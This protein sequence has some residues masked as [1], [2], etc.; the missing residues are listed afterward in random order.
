MNFLNPKDSTEPTDSSADNPPL[1]G[2]L[3]D[4]SNMFN[5]RG[6]YKSNGFSFDESEIINDFNG[7]LIYNIPLYNYKLPGDLIFDVG[8][9]YNGS[10]SHIINTGDTSNINNYTSG[11]YNMNFPEW[12]INING[13]GVQTLNFETNFFSNVIETGIVSGNDVHA[14]IPG[15]HFGNQLRDPSSINPDKINILAGD[16]SIISLVNDRKDTSITGN[17]SYEGKELFY[18]AR[19]SV[20]ENDGYWRA[21]NRKVELMRGDGLIFIF[22][23][24]KIRFSDFDTVSSI[25][26][27]LRPK[28]LLLKSIKDRYNNSINLSYSLEHPY[29]M[30]NIFGRPLITGIGF[31][32]GFSTSPVNSLYFIFGP[33]VLKIDHRS[34]INGSYS[35]KLT[36]PVAF[37]PVDQ[38]DIKNHRG[39]I[40][41]IRNILGQVNTINYENY[42]RTFSPVINPKLSPATFMLALNNL[43][44][45]TNFRNT[46]GG[47]R[48]YSYFQD[49]SIGVSLV[50]YN[51]SQEII[52]SE[53][54][55]K[56]YGRDPFYVNMLSSK[57][58]S[59]EY[60]LPISTTTFSYE[61]Y[62]NS[63][64]SLNVP[65]DTSDFYSSTRE[66]TNNLTGT[67]WDVTTSQQKKIN[68]YKV[69]P[70]FDP[71][72]L[73]VELKDV[74]GITKIVRENNKIN[75]SGDT[76]IHTFKYEHGPLISNIGF[77][78]SFL[79]NEKKTDYHGITKVNSFQYEY[80]PVVHDELDYVSAYMVRKLT[81]TDPLNNVTVTTFNYFIYK[82]SYP[83]V[84]PLDT[85]IYYKIQLSDSIRKYRPTNI[86]TY[87]K[88]QTYL[89]DTGSSEGYKGQLY[90]ERL[91]DANNLSNFIETEYEYYKRDTV[92]LYLYGGFD[93]LPKKEGNLKLISNPNG[94]VQKFFYHLTDTS[95]ATPPD[96]NSDFPDYPL[97]YY[98]IKYN[99]GAVADS[100][101]MI[102]DR[103]LP[104]RIDIY[105]ILGGTTDTLSKVYKTYTADGSPAKLID[106]N[107]YLTEFKYEPMHRINSITLPGDFSDFSDSVIKIIH[108]D[109]LYITREL[110]SEAWGLYNSE[111]GKA[112]YYTAHT[113]S[114]FVGCNNSQFEMD[115]S[116][117]NSQNSNFAYIQFQNDFP[118]KY[119]SVDSAIFRMWPLEFIADR[120]GTIPKNDYKTYIKG[121]SGFGN[122][123]QHECDNIHWR[124][125]STTLESF[126]DTINLPVQNNCQYT[127]R[128]ADIKNLIMNFSN[129]NK[130]LYGI[131]LNSAFIGEPDAQT[132]PKFYLDMTYCNQ[133]TNWF[134]W[135]TPRVNIFGYLDISDTLKIP[136]IKGGT[137]KYKYDD[138][139]HTINVYSIRNSI[140][141]NYSNIK[142]SIDGFG[143]IKQKDIYTSAS[144]FN[145]YRY[146][147]N[148]MN[149]P[150]VNFDAL[151]DST[152]FSY[153]GLE[154]LIKTR[155]PDT[156]ST[157]NSYSY[158]DSLI[159]SFGTVKN[160]IEK[161]RFTDEEGNPFDK[162]FDAVG[163][164][165][166]EVKFVSIPAPEEDFPS[167]SLI[168][169]YK[170]DSLYRV[171]QVKTP[172]DKNIYYS[173]DGY[174]RQI[175]RITPD[176]G[177]TDFIFDNSNNL[178]YSQDANQRNINSFLY[179]FRNY[180]G[181]NRLT[182]IGDGIFDI[183]SPFDGTQSEQ[184]Q[185]TNYYT[186]NVYDTTSNSVVTNLFTGVTGY[187]SA[188]N[189]TKGNLAATAYRTRKTDD[190]NFK[191]YRYDIRGR[192]IKMWNI[193]SGFDTL[194]TDYN[195]NSQ[196]Q[197]TNF[198][199]T[200]LTE[201]KTYRNTYDFA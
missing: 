183:D 5:E 67:G 167:T 57:K 178:T 23:E 18:K 193:I 177:Q 13:I 72:D 22:V 188:L 182:G 27:A 113:L 80:F 34:E 8:L 100:S 75:S 149:K 139:N 122:A 130:E 105:K 172:N 68:Y 142:Y 71:E 52:R 131:T 17:Y 155:N 93:N 147:F 60:G 116:Y 63:S 36:Q 69:Y 146:K 103:R 10:V 77:N 201:I 16:G 25:S 171:T 163:N 191:Y 94:Q 54:D 31:D 180:D 159:Y 187:T 107:R 47:R 118:Q 140:L 14:I 132:Y 53:N 24:S 32:M 160:L 46:L 119:R 38:G 194:I 29:R 101:E 51:A 88:I 196:D 141:N 96:P 123:Y 134:D 28:V 62:D 168:T 179:T 189:Y 78:G 170:Y 152:N 89:S 199:H 185:P 181:L 165:I 73:P 157:L 81:E 50:Q 7:N 97:F 98:K 21:R 12:I 158:Y 176:A 41:E 82:F 164:L 198:S 150:S 99:T 39:T 86:L 59:S 37:L 85:G 148:Y 154:R 145:T 120:N 175:K 48:G 128:K 162:Y 174:G 117:R 186:I 190:W 127:E 112:D 20:I 121:V 70:L 91:Y 45:L 161:Q 65:V 56:G 61:Y 44:R 84:D 169:D 11:K 30:S 126:V 104:I 90:S 64:N 42:V 108:K 92:G 173:Y 106:Q 6:F 95:E 87:Q 43:K 136:V 156:S 1:A 58:D 76:I 79:I 19:V 74:S 166:R 125:R 114:E 137:I 184:S 35:L 33:Q 15:Y 111:N 40:S 195:Y 135:Y 197:V 115:I 55:Y 124:R 133:N 3:K 66:K 129:S 192:V 110:K 143:N 109:S 4:V 144:T 26:P 49:D 153:D 151:S 9:T 138:D 83:F 200:G 102:Y 2:P